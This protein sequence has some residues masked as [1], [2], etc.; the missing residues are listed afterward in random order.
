ME[1]TGE[2]SAAS[3]WC[4]CGGGN[5][6]EGRDCM[7]HCVGS[8]ESL[9]G[10]KPMST[11]MHAKLAGEGEGRHQAGEDLRENRL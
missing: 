10:G 2:S 6:A 4:L 7:W 3:Y 11:E 8:V 1:G 9:V 5:A